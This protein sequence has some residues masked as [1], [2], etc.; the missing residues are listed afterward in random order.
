MGEVEVARSGLDLELYGGEF[1]VLLGPSGSGKSTAQHPRRARPA[2]CRPRS[3]RRASSPSSAMPSSRAI[4][5]STSA[6]SFS[7][8]TSFPVS[9]RARTSRWSPDRH[10]PHE[11]GGGAGAGRARRPHGSSRRSSPAVNS[12]GSP[13]RASQASGGAAAT[14]PRALDVGTGIRVLE[15][16]ARINADIGTTTVVITQ[17]GDRRHGHSRH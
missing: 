13:L 7:S 14:N 2:E 6:S 5:A 4:A 17:R 16:I 15:A 9:R 11:S 1:V 10:R 8:T 12:S 3:L